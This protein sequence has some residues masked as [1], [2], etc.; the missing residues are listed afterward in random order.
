MAS[1]HCTTSDLDAVDISIRKSDL[2]P[3]ENLQA[4]QVSVTQ[5]SEEMT[6]QT[7]DTLIA[8]YKTL[9]RHNLHLLDTVYA[10]DICFIDPLHQ[11]RGLD[12]LMRYFEVL[13]HNVQSIEFVIH[14]RLTQ[15]H[16]VCLFW[17]MSYSHAKLN[18]GKPILV[19]G[20]S[21][22]KLNDEYQICYHRDYFDVGQMLYE[23]IP[24]LGHVIRKIKRG[25]G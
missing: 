18:A 8:L 25:V 19:D 6:Q 12:A 15:P 14:E 24:V 9:N 4:K 22:L 17:Q 23:P 20:S 7:A 1:N 13:Y 10:K 2:L 16:Q 21:H 5:T 3:Q 11:I